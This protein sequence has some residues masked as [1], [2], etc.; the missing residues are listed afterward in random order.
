[1][2]PVSALSDAHGAGHYY[3]AVSGNH[4]NHVASTKQQPWPI[5]ANLLALRL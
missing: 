3:Y 4:Q 1:M 2:A 5:G